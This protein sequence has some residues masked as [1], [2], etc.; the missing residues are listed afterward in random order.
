MD[1]YEIGIKS[2]LADDRLRLSSALFFYDLK[3]LQVSRNFGGQSNTTEN[4]A[5]ARV[6]GL[7]VDVEML[8]T[9][10]L[11]LRS[12]IALVDSEYLDY[13]AAVL[14]PLMVPPYGSEPLSGGL[15]VS[16]QSLLRS[17]DEAAYVGLDYGRGLSGGA[18][19]RVSIDY[20]Y[21]GD[22]YFDFSA[23][24]DDRVAQA[25]RVR[26]VERARCL[27]ER[28]QRLGDRSLG[29]KLDGCELLRR[30]R[31]HE[32]VISRVIRGSANV[33]NRFQAAALTEPR[34][35]LVPKSFR[36]LSATSSPRQGR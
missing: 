28:R 31:R 26:F 17:P 25:R 20:S 6:R 32:C 30:R 24:A 36:A 22:Y 19:I 4:A 7:E 3:D 23:V 10:N 5:G 16:G 35:T 14:V 9:D 21:K 13:T 11:S 1:S 12:G 8:V 29:R 33:R 34:E 2:D 15:N 27:C 18:S